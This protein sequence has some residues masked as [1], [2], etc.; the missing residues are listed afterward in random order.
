MDPLPSVDDIAKIAE[1]ETEENAVLIA[2]TE[3][4]CLDDLSLD[5]DI[6]DDVFDTQYKID[7]SCL[8]ELISALKVQVSIV[9]S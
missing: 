1:S 7:S 4:S 2:Q 9:W 3:I 5:G 8:H 6:L